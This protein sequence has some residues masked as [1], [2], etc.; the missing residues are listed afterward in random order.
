MAH[1]A[2]RFVHLAFV[3]AGAAFT[4]LER[5][6]MAMMI[7]IG[8]IAALVGLCLSDCYRR[9]CKTE[10]GGIIFEGRAREPDAT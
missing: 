9:G 8:R 3:V 4:T 10:N 1:R 5:P 6:M 7:A 2:C